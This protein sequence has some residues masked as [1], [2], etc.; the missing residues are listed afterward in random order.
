M[1]MMNSIPCM[2]MRGG[3]SRGP[4]LRMRDLPDSQEAQAEI[5]LNL[6]GSGHALQIDGI[7]GG[8]PLTSKVAIVEHSSHPEA[9]VDYL[10]AQVDVLNRRV[11]FNPNCGNMLSAVGPY[12]LETGLVEPQEGTTVV[13]VRNLNTQ[14]LIECHVPTPGRQVSYEGSTSISGVPGSAAGIQLSFLDIMGSKTGSLL[15]TGKACDSIEGVD[16][17]CLDAAT[18]IIMLDAADLG[19]RGDESPA[20]LDANSVLLERLESIR[21]KAGL[22]M[23]L[24]D[25]R[26]SVLPKPVL[27]STAC[28]RASTLSTRYFVPHRCHKAIA[29][30]GAIAVASA[31]SVPGTI[32]HRI[33]V[34]SGR[35][36]AGECLAHVRL[37]HPSGF[38][39]LDVEHRQGNASDI[40][41]VSLIRTARKIMSG[42]IF[43]TASTPP[44]ETMPA[45][46]AS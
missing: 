36:S 7:G 2:I 10:F 34:E 45:L 19:L 1:T 22:C 25:V 38:I 17:T 9:D 26:N 27:V 35:M 5:L 43:Y 41:R 40:A 11:D 21:L 14:R 37:E 13:R 18:P 6:M 42:T 3:T 32:A 15:P 24:G 16:V 29:V 33:A 28:D 44:G 4:V 23:G 8:D 31:V 46:Q 20:E 30:T 12:A 39:D